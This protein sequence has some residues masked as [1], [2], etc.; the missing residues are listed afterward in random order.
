[1]LELSD[2][3]YTRLLDAAAASGMTP[4]EWIAAR[5]PQPAASAK[6]D[7]EP[8]RTLAERFAGRVGV[9]DSGGQVRA[10]EDI[11]DRFAEHLKQKRRAGRLRRSPRSTTK[12]PRIAPRPF[13]AHSSCRSCAA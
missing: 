7:A 8:T 1:M 4:V 2:E 9:I 13:H 12:R 6:D 11:G 3:I 10:A 5:L